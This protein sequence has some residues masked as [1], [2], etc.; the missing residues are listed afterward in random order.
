MTVKI[1]NII[2]DD[3][4]RLDGI[5]EAGDIVVSQYVAFDGSVDLLTMPPATQR[6]FSLAAT[7]SGS[8][9]VGAFTLAQLQAIKAVA[10]VGQPVTVA[11]HRGTFSVIITGIQEIVNIADHANPTADDWYTATITMIEV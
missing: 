4:L 2:L 11:H 8:G 3:D 9:S 5:E 1:G 6:Q 7:P 10:A